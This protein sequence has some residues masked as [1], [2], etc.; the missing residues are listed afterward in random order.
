MKNKVLLIVTVALLVL[1]AGIF[2]LAQDTDNNGLSSQPE[3]TPTPTTTQPTGTDGQ[4]NDSMSQSDRYVDYSEQTYAENSD[5]KRVIFFHASWCPT[6]KIANTDFENNEEQI[7]EDVIVLKTD[8]DTQTELKNKYGITYQHTFVQVDAN[9][10]E[11]A[12][13]NGG[14]VSQ[15]KSQL[16]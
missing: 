14:G 16:N 15:L 3:L 2:L 12:K 8:Y 11:V 13:W 9:G 4:S 10:N 5:K 1:G 6:C 7:P